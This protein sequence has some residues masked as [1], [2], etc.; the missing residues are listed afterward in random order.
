LRAVQAKVRGAISIVSAIATGMGATMGVS[1]EVRA[2]IEATPGEGI[3]LD[4]G[5]KSLSQRLVTSAVRKIVP[6]RDLARTHI[7]VNLQ[8]EIPA[9][10]GLKSSSS[11]SSAVAL[12]CAKLFGPEVNDSRVLLAGVDA[13]I[14]TG[15]SIT[16]AYDDACACYYGGFNVTDNLKR[17]LVRRQ[18]IPSG[19]AAVIFIPASSRR[20][21][22]RRLR[23]Q[24]SAFEAAWQMARRSNY[25]GAMLLN[26]ITAGPF[27]NSD[28]ALIP[29]LLEAGA[30]GASVSG[31]GTAV[32]ATV[33][34]NAVSG[35]R[36]VF[37]SLDGRIITSPA[38]NKKAEVHEVRD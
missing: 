34:Q 10:Y 14:E 38:N 1:L 30:L 19:I 28:P 33:R 8:S 15:I 2:R 31:N 29:R 37:S 6:A 13:S 16:G 21:N 5:S 3:T 36:K 32:A 27:L 35:V 20:R 17:R 12:A 24:K 22:P 11:I 25:W 18:A 7:H 9:G 4:A 23:E 26:G